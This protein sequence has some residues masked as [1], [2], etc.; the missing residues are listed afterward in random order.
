MWRKGKSKESRILYIVHG[1][2]GLFLG[3]GI[4][5]ISGEGRLD[6]LSLIE[7]KG[8][9]KFYLSSNKGKI[10]RNARQQTLYNQ[11]KMAAIVNRN[12]DLICFF[13]FSGNQSI[14]MFMKNTS[15]G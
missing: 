1:E 8:G 12:F 2:G 11:I 15:L 6:Q 9:G 4:F 14:L 7:C 10:L 13:C 3:G 5:R